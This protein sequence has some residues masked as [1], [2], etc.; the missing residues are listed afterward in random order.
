VARQLMDRLGGSLSIEDNLAGGTVVTLHPPH[1]SNPLTA[2]R[3][4]APT[5]SRD[6][7][8][9]ARAASPPPQSLSPRQQR[10]VLLLADADEVGPSAV[11]QHLGLS[12]TT[13][14]RELVAL[15]GMGLVASDGS[16]KR[17]LT[18]E[19]IAAVERLVREEMGA[20]LHRG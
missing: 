14:F 20:A 8:L 3:P 18:A 17:R 16:G 4:P 7:R 12:L 9:A 10:L 13:A 19:G 5:P 1:I 2:A 6:A 11:S 15:E